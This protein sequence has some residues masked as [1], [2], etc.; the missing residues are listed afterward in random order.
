MSKITLDVDKQNVETLLVILK[1]LKS[2]LIKNIS[3]DEKNILNKIQEKKAIKQ[4]AVLEDEF[5]QKPTN[6]KYLSRDA[7]KNKLH[8]KKG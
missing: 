2:D 6:S 7:F 4:Q 8:S 3:I 5:I 1:N